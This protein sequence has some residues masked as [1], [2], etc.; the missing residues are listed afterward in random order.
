MGETFI[1]PQTKNSRDEHVNSG[2][3]GG[4]MSKSVTT[5]SIIFWMV[6]PYKT[7]MSIE[8]DSTHVKI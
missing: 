7:V 6:K 1:P 2:T 3:N 4:K 8:T 5:L